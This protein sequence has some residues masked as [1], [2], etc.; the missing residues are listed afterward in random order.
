MAPRRL[1]DVRAHEEVVGVQRRR[2]GLVVADASD[3]RRQVDD[4]IRR[5]GGDGRLG[6]RVGEVELGLGAVTTAP[7]SRRRAT[8]TWPRKPEP[9]VTR[10]GRPDQKSLMAAMLRA[11]RASMGGCAPPTRWSSAGT[12]CPAGPRWPRWR[13]PAA[14][15]ADGRRTDRRLRPAPHRSRGWLRAAHPGAL[16]PQAPPSTKAGDGWAGH[17]S[18][19]RRARS[20]S[21]TRRPSSSRRGQRRSS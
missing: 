1:D 13:W 16:P 12:T 18:S 14:G 5:G 2:F 9:P 6:L 15:L 19:G 21:S 20:T 3:P 4:L 11:A 7:A 8:T 17:P 10:T